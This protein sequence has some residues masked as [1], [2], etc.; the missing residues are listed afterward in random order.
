MVYI[1]GFLINI[2]RNYYISTFGIIK[3]S[4]NQVENQSAIQ[5][6]IKEIEC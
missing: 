5:F 2:Y 3:Y 6:Q 4:K 1:Y